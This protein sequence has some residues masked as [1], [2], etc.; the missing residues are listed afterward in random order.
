[1]YMALP[2]YTTYMKLRW[3]RLTQNG[4]PYYVLVVPTSML[5]FRRTQDTGSIV[6]LYNYILLEDTNQKP[7]FGKIHVH[8]MIKI[9]I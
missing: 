9:V 5:Y 1:M 4:I 8:H 2:P 7:F 3:Y 6:L